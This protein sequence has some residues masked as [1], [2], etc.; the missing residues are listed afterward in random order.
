MVIKLGII[1]VC[2]SGVAGLKMVV[3]LCMMIKGAEDLQLT[4]EIV[5]KK[6]FKMH[7]TKIAD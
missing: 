5:E 3:H 2:S 6:K 7:F 4:H 1:R